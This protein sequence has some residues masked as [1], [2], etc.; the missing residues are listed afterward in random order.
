LLQDLPSHILDE[1]GDKQQDK[2]KQQ[3]EDYDKE[4]PKKKL[5]PVEQ[6]RTE[7]KNLVG[8]LT[9][10]IKA[11]FLGCEFTYT[12]KVQR[13]LRVEEYENHLKEAVR[14]VLSNISEDKDAP[15]VLHFINYLG[16]NRECHIGVKGETL[17]YLGF[18]DGKIYFQSMIAK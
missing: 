11:D 12:N 2:K 3:G 6:V 7:L 5:I 17:L 14:A 9:F 4:K 16:Q 8:T 1:D 13:K 10:V 18:I 15:T